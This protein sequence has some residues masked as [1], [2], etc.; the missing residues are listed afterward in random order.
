MD[1]S[2]FIEKW[3]S[4]S[5]RHESQKLRRKIYAIKQK[6]EIAR[7]EASPFLSWPYPKL[8]PSEACA[9]LSWLYP[10]LALS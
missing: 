1:S 6:A 4:S 5:V 9:I 10:K 7:S 3:G 2:L 8:A